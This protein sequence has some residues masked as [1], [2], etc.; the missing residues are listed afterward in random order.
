MIKKIIQ[1]SIDTKQLIMQNDNVIKQIKVLSHDII[2]VLKN[3]GKVILAGNG[4][5]F[6]DSIHICAEFVVRFAKNRK[7]L[8]AISLGCNSSILTAAANDFNFDDAFARELEAVANVNDI[9]IP[10]STSGDSKNIIKAVEYANT[11]S[12]KTICMTGDKGGKIS[13]ITDCIKVPSNITARIQ[14]SH[15]MIGH[16]ICELVENYFVNKK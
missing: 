15:I 11:K 16:I 6:A 8:S 3:N 1:Q 10:I 2:K 9:F 7:S 4:G 13:H 14:E 5:S 12:I